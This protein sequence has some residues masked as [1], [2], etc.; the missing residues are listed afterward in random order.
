MRYRP[1]VLITL[2]L[3]LGI[4]IGYVARPSASVML[5]MLALYLAGL[6]LWLIRNGQTTTS[7]HNYKIAM[8][9]AVLIVLTGVWRMTFALAACP[10]QLSQPKVLC[11]A[12]G[13]VLDPPWPTAW[14]PRDDRHN[15][16]GYDSD[17]FYKNSLVVRLDQIE[18]PSGSVAVAVRAKVSVQGEIPFL[19]QRGDR[20]ELLGW[21]AAFE[22]PHNPGQWDRQYFWHSRGVYCQFAIIHPNTIKVLARH[23]GCPVLNWFYHLRWRCTERLRDAVGPR[24]GS[25]LAALVLGVR[26]FVEEAIIQEF[27]VTG[28]IHLLA[29]SGMHVAILAWFVHGL[30]RHWRLSPSLRS[31]LI[32]LAANVYGLLTVLQPSVMRAVVMVCCY[33][34]APLLGRRSDG[35]N[36]LAAA[37]LIILWHTPQELLLPGFQL[38][39]AACLAILAG[40]E[41]WHDWQA[42]RRLA[43]RT[44]QAQ[45]GETADVPGDSD[46]T[47]PQ[48]GAQA[49][50]AGKMAAMRAMAR[51]LGNYLAAS[52]A[53]SC[54]AWF[55]TAPLVAYHF[56]LCPL[57]TPI[58]TVI[59]APLVTLL[60]GITLL[61]LFS[62]LGIGW[63]ETALAAILVWSSALWE[64]MVTAVARTPT[65]TSLVPPLAL[66]IAL[67]YLLLVLLPLLGNIRRQGLILLICWLVVMASGRLRPFG[68]EETGVVVL[69]V[70]H[71][72][73]I[74]LK[75]PGNR[76]VIYDCGSGTPEIGKRVIWPFLRRRGVTNLSAI[77]LSHYDQD[78]YNGFLE[79]AALMPVQRLVINSIFRER[80]GPLL[81]EAKKLG[82]AVVEVRDGQT[83]P[84][85]P[86]ITF[87]YPGS[88]LP[89]TRQFSNNE[90]SLLALCEIDGCRLLLTAD[91]G[92]RS[93]EL[94]LA[95]FDRT[96]TI[97][98]VQ[99]PHH[100]SDLNG[101]D[102]LVA[103]L[104]PTHA[105]VC[106]KPG[107]PSDTTLACYR[108]GRVT[109]WD[110]SMH[111]A[112]MFVPHAGQWLIRPF[113]H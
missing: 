68:Q 90:H 24:Y 58:A 57:L 96:R 52:F 70:G 53:I 104:R 67:F 92:P 15:S 39:F 62:P 91:I 49:Q 71:G 13:V 82:V 17:L 37:A 93:L 10:L 98:I 46:P 11:R 21:L 22:A 111:G 95:D 41:A 30:L 48:P 101:T 9:V 20:V 26:N 51:H 38:S 77:I 32:M 76:H 4:W 87:Y 6:S 44:A 43:Q 100:G 36:A 88:R 103:Q 5:V 113:R 94:F 2:L 81:L 27:A 29:I 55:G 7:A 40:N 83:L 8:V 80:G 23:Q 109:L 97:A 33:L 47:P 19:L 107:F 16:H 99:I 54:V 56:F 85:L 35:L 108:A 74:Y 28:L 69:H 66:P 31:L 105:F 106:T 73:A 72:N 86:G 89:T 65:N 45:I 18:Q 59:M 75:L 1:L 3:A 112:V 84:Q 102:E 110:T 14:F 50:D 64:A 61:L 42:E 34:T 60:F 63:G 25:L 12:T 78:H 79:I